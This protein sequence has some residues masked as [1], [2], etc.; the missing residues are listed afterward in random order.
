MDLLHRLKRGAVAW[1]RIFGD[2]RCMDDYMYARCK[3][4][5][6][7]HQLASSHVSINILYISVC[8]M[9]PMFAC[10]LGRR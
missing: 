6:A 4:G 8:I 7:M 3:D 2:G 5:E 10:G 1:L 9:S